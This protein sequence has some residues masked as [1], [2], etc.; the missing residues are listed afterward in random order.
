[1]CN[2]GIVVM[3]MLDRLVAHLVLELVQSCLALPAALQHTSLSTSMA[4]ASRTNRPQSLSDIVYR[5]VGLFVPR[6]G[7]GILPFGLQQLTI[8][9]G[10]LNQSLGCSSSHLVRW[11]SGLQIS[12]GSAGRS[13]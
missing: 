1:M 11:L 5:L 7:N 3:S 8:G 6:L 9:N 2:A 10:V 13:S 4:P 12:M